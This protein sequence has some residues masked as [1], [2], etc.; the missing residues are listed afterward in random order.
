MDE[1]LR[2]LAS[3]NIQD[4]ELVKF[5]MLEDFSSVIKAKDLKHIRFTN[6]QNWLEVRGGKLYLPTMFIQSNAVNLTVRG[7]HSFDHDIDYGIKV[8]AGQVLLSKLKKHDPLLKPQKAKKKGWFDLYYAITGTLDEYDIKTSKRQVQ[9]DFEKS[10]RR[11]QEIKR[12]LEK[13]FS[14]IKTVKT[15]N[16]RDKAPIPEYDEVEETDDYL[17]EIK[18]K[19]NSTSSKT[20][21][22]YDDNDEGDDELLEF[23]EGGK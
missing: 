11:K 12:L 5:K 1:K 3:V 22:E 16:W 8:N 2:V 15:E 21:P 7:E 19:S 13:E 23:D 14:S 18:T 17:D 10:E 6:M 20:I 4:G 9:K